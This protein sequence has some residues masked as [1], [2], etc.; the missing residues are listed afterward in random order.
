MQTMRNKELIFSIFLAIAF[1]FNVKAQSGANDPTFNTYDDGTY[2]D[3]KA[4]DNY[5]YST[6]IQ[7][8]GKIVVG[9]NFTSYNGF[10]SKRIARLNP[11]GTLDNSFNVG[12]GFNNIVRTICIQ[13]DGKIIIGGN[14][15]SYNDTTRT[16]IIRLNPDGSIDMSFKPTSP[17]FNTQ[18]F[19]IAIQTDGKILAGGDFTSYN[20]VSINKIARLNTDGSLD[21]DFNIG[22]G[23]NSTVRT[24]S[25][26][27]DGKIIVGGSFTS[28][29]ETSQSRIT[30]LN[31]DGS[32][33]L[34]FNF[35]VD[36]PV[37]STSIQSDGKIIAGGDF[38]RNIVRIN[39]NGS[40]DI[41]FYTL[42]LGITT[43]YAT[44][45]Q[46]DGK[47]I[48]GGSCNG[49]MTIARFNTNGTRNNWNNTE[50]LSVFN[51]SSSSVR[52]ISFQSDGKMIVGGL[53]NYTTD[54]RKSMIVRLETDDNLDNE[55]NSGTG[56][57]SGVETIKVLSD[58]RILIGGRFISF[59]NNPLYRIACLNND[60]SLSSNFNQN[61]KFNGTI[62]CFSIQADGKIVVG[63]NYSY[64][65]DSEQN[66][67]ARLN[68]D[69]SHDEG[70]I[71]GSG[72]NAWVY[73]TSIQSDG[74]IIVGG[75]F[76]S[77]NNTES[78]YIARLN[79]DGSL[80]NGFII[81]TGFDRRI[82]AIS[83]QSDGKILVGGDFTT[84]N[85]ITIKKIARLNT[86][87]SLD[88][89][90]N[91]GTGFSSIVNC[92]S[93][94]SDGKI[95]VGGDFS[96]FNG[97]GKRRIARLNSDGSY[98]DSFNIGTGFDSDVNT[99]TV[100]SDGKIIVGGEFTSYNEVEANRIVR[101]NSD[102]SLDNTFNIGT[103][104]NSDVRAISVQ[105][106]GKILVGGYF[107]SY[108]GILRNRMAR[109]EGNKNIW[110][111]LHSNNWTS[112]HNWNPSVVPDENTHIA[113]PAVENQPIIQNGVNAKARK[114]IIENNAILTLENES[115]LT[116]EEN[117]ENDGVM[118]LQSGSNNTGSMIVKGEISGIGT[119]KI[120]RF[121]SANK[122][123]LISSPIANGTSG[124]FTGIWLR[125]YNET[126]NAFGPY[127]TP[128]NIPL[129]PGQGFSNW[130][131]QD[132]TRTFVGNINN[133]TIGAIDLPR[134]NLGWNL[135]GNPYT[136]AIDWDAS[137]GWT[138][139][140]VANS[141]YIWNG[142]ESQY[143]IWNGTVG[144]HGGSQFIPMGQGFFV[145]STASNASITMNKNIRVHNS[146]AFMKNQ[147]PANIIRIKVAS[148]EKSDESLIA[149]RSNIMDEFDY[150]FDA[151]KLRGDASAPQI[152]T[153]KSETETAIC[154]YNDIFKVFGQFVYFEPASTLEHVLLYTHTLDGSDLPILFDHITGATIYPNIPYTF[155]PSEN[156]IAKRFEFIKSSPSKLEE[157]SYNSIMIW[158]SN[159]N[160]YVDNL[161]DEILKEIRMY[162]M[163]GK[164][165]FKTNG[166]PCS[167]NEYSKGFYI[168]S[169]TTNKSIIN[170]KI[171]F[172]K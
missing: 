2:G 35:G 29:N 64:V 127:I 80:D 145:Q 137:V 57:S 120:E 10:E 32:R 20:G 135:I 6:A 130:T 85:G 103:G 81:G 26:Q 100:Q 154:G 93:I 55:F 102:G 172:I 39:S 17:W 143:A 38:N 95:L 87:G 132:E 76:T 129:T 50:L 78:K 31:S 113:I 96:T 138:K 40:F 92:I 139:T 60:G 84:Y 101:L 58:D 122:W 150:Q 140:N 153:K 72:F 30:R 109:L 142:E 108:N 46:F 74:K 12:S 56:F 33:D 27:S 24:I 21:E 147:D 168:V 170:R 156:H 111:G 106:D 63:G 94:Q 49:I 157:S 25:I 141:V 164:L 167:I 159:G 123:H 90:F 148:A 134:T 22:S 13:P 146:V 1:C 117:I 14:F 112:A 48:I 59:N 152:Y 65:N 83:I 126:T 144:I 41:Y 8:D 36:G 42:S 125:P 82:Q 116:V 45:I 69:G 128:T 4:F 161:G 9:G 47:I 68:S 7:A 3:G 136:S 114:I 19:T 62:F 151:T 163:Q 98:D 70:F 77:Y 119:A 44:S 34:S 66:R 75:L 133:E 99:I 43:V 71:I 89:T 67:I 11:D 86:D 155:M 149:I 52:C 158:E 73:S 53:I 171:N 61:V 165:I 162:D 16:G 110:T 97:T 105:S 166:Y 169:I 115:R 18:V 107:S 28:F 23:F 121:L 118:L 54:P 79:T 160:L 91:P 124:I 5:V 131:Y 104:F 88:N 51:A 37:Y 15:T